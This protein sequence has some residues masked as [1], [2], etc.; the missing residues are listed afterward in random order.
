MNY[1]EDCENY[2]P[3]TNRP[4][5]LEAWLKNLPSE[6]ELSIDKCF[7]IPTGYQ[8]NAALGN[9]LWCYPLPEYKGLPR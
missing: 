2:K 7:P 1:C 3:I 4:R 8:L 5:K 9:Q 6:A